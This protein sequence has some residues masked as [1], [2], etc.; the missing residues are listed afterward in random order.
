MN[1]LW[2]QRGGSKAPA[3]VIIGGLIVLLALA[4]GWQVSQSAYGEAMARLADATVRLSEVRRDAA[5]LAGAHARSGGEAPQARIAA[6]LARAGLTAEVRPRGDAYMVSIAA[7]RGPVLIGWLRDVE[8]NGIVTVSAS[9][10]RNSD[11]TVAG[12]FRFAE[13]TR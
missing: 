13:A 4:I 6:A 3:L 7:A 5:R 10:R 12:E 1:A 9:L 11:A 2:H 8:S